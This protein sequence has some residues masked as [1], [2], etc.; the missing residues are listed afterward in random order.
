MLKVISFYL[1][2]F[3]S[4]PENDEVWGK[5]FTEWNSV[6]SATSLYKGHNQPRIPKNDNYYNLLDE[7]TLLW[8]TKLAKDYK[9]YGFCIYHYW[10]S[11]K[12]LLNKPLELLRESKKIHFPYCICWA[13]E[14]WTNAWAARGKPKSFLKQKYGDKKEWK[15]HF[16]YLLKFFKDPDYI[17][18]NNE[19][20]LVIY[21]P[22]SIPNLNERLDYWNELAIEN[23]F[24]GLCLSYQQVDFRMSPNSDDSRFKYSIEYQPKYALTDLE[25]EKKTYS[26]GLRHFI[27]KKIE[28]VNLRVIENILEYRD[29]Y[30]AQKYGPN[31]Y[32][33][34]KVAEKVVSRKAVDKK[35]VAGMF[36]GYDDTPR[37]GRKGAV[38]QSSPVLFSKYLF[39]QVENV[40]K[41]YSNDYL[42]MFAW[43]EWGESGYLEP[44]SNFQYAYLDA[45]R[46]AVDEY[47]KK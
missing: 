10:F 44:D 18:E 3:H 42:F 12:L 47:D 1:P 31:V 46:N 21:R 9:V 13:N 14:S 38:I 8:Q 16:D 6:K 40:K 7:N 34:S 15:D 32:Q 26:K 22:E 36:V 39:K 19:P 35:S 17:V 29:N 5:G 25:A 43:N 23:G 4:I 30:K 37:K 41:N 24:N 27:R 33:Y 28:N 2:Q 45:I 20:M 11:G